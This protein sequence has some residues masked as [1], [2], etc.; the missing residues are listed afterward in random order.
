MIQGKGQI[1]EKYLIRW[2]SLVTRSP[3]PPLTSC[4]FLPL[5]LTLSL[6]LLMGMDTD[7]NVAVSLCLPYGLLLVQNILWTS[8]AP[9]NDL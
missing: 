3:H 2:G 4:F 1:H 9:R 7:A 5:S 6:V 8:A